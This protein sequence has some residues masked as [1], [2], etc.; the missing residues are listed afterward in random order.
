LK[1]VARE[2]GKCK[3]DLV[4]VQEV[5]SEKEGTEQTEDYTFFYGEG[6]E[7]D[8]LG[9]GFFIHKKSYQQLGEQSLLMIGCH[10]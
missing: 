5:R 2:L 3:L 4:G 6:T 9:K 10:V 7:D 1:T 8:R